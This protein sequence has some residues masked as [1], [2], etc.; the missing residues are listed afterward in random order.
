[1]GGD[2]DRAEEVVGDP[3]TEVAEEI[4]IAAVFGQHVGLTAIFYSR[5]Q[6]QA[7]LLCVGAGYF[8]EYLR[9]R[10]VTGGSLACQAGALG[11]M[12]YL[13]LFKSEYYKISSLSRMGSVSSEGVSAKST[14]LCLW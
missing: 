12:T 1:M 10:I 4:P 3:L 14:K 13:F 7:F 9:H 2:G 6:A 11:Y 5:P 8:A